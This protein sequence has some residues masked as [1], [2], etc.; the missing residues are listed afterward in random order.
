VAEYNLYNP[1]L[2]ELVKA[3]DSTGRIADFVPMLTQHVQFFKFLPFIQGNKPNGHEVHFEDSLPDVALRMFGEGASASFGTLGS[4]E[5]KMSLEDEWIRI[6]CETADINGNAAKYI[7]MQTEMKF[8]AMT[9]MRA[10]KIFYGNPLVYPRDCLGMVPR[11]SSLSARN[12]QNI[13]DAGGTQ[14]YNMSIWLMGLGEN[15]FTGTFPNGPNGQGAGGIQ[16][17]DRGKREY[18]YT[19][20]GVEKILDVYLSKFMWNWGHALINWMWCVRIA[21]ID[22]VNL[23]A[24]EGD[25]ADLPNLMRK[26]VRRLP[27]MNSASLKMEGAKLGDNPRLVWVMNRATYDGF[28]TQVTQSIQ[29]GGQFTTAVATDGTTYEMFN[30]IPITIF[31]GLVKNETRVT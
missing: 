26:A 5:E 14:S 30:G 29:A 6:P 20:S 9:Y 13:I 19:E 23:A 15:A 4:F 3:M 31:D 17:E 27:N 16:H 21:N 24:M 8:R 12:G 25:E 2:M 7:A 18:F 22:Y 28:C 10:S 1:T 11:Y